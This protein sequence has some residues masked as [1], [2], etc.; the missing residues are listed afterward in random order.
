MPGKRFKSLLPYH[1]DSWLL[2]TGPAAFHEKEEEFE[3]SIP[4]LVSENVLCAPL[5]LIRTLDSRDM[6][7]LLL[8]YD[9]SEGRP[10]MRIL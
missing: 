9:F 3:N 10:D 7:Q 2:I 4:K 5:V 6:D 1:T 8:I